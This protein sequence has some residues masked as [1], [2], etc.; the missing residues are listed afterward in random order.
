M[1]ISI[2]TY[3]MRHH[4]Q[5]PHMRDSF[6]SKQQSKTD[7]LKILI[8]VVVQMKDVFH[9][10]LLLYVASILHKKINFYCKICADKNEKWLDLLKLKR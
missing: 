4:D 6:D 2:D 9:H 3:C 7:L 8:S 10:T 5:T 1:Y